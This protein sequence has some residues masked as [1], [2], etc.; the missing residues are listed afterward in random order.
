MTVRSCP[1]PL[2]VASVLCWLLTVS[3]CQVLEQSG[4]MPE[5]MLVGSKQMARKESESRLLYLKEGDPQ[6]MRWLLGH[7]LETGMTLA[8]VNKVFG[9]VGVE[10]TND[11]WIKKNN[12]R[13]RRNDE[14]YR[15]G[16]DSQGQ[17][18]YL[19]FRDDQL[20]NFDPTEFR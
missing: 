13:Y 3:G 8:D 1:T 15:W 5:S 4:F 17:S 6:A 19:V 14:T 2:A 10:E 18:V 16:P 9:Q 20:V 7:R 12:A 11:S